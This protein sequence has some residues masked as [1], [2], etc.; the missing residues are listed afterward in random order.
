MPFS[1]ARDCFDQAHAWQYRAL[2]ASFGTTTGL[3]VQA[4]L[5]RQSRVGQAFGT[6]CDILKDGTVMTM[7]RACTGA[8]GHPVMIGSAVSVRDNLRFLADHL[9][10]ND[11]D[12]EA[13]FEELRKWIMNDMRA[14]SGVDTV[15]KKL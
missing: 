1:S 7:H 9:K 13:M 10:L 11:A 12:R 15:I 5:G 2:R 3:I 4:I 14:E 6:T 8:T